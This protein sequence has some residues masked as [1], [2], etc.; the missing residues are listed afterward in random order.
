MLVPMDVLTQLKQ[1][2]IFQKVPEEQLQWLANKGE[3]ITYQPEEFAFQTGDPI[4]RLIIVFEGHAVFKLKQGNH[5]RVMGEM[6][7]GD[8]TG[9][10]P[11]SRADKA[12]GNA[13]VIEK[14]TIF[15]LK[16]EDFPEMK[17]TQDALTTSLVHLM[18]T[19]IREFTKNQQQDDKMMALGKL[20]AGLAHELNNPSAAIVRS[21]HSLESH[22]RILPEGFKR[23]LNIKVTDAQA[24]FVNRVLVEK[25]A[26]GVQTLTMMERSEKEDDLVDWLDDH[27]IDDADRLAENL[28][29]FGYGA[30][31]LEEMQ[32]QVPAES[33]ESVIFWIDQTLTTEKL[34]AEIA[35]ASGRINKLVSSIKSYTHMDQAPIKA[36]TD[37]TIGL[38]NTLTMLNHKINSNG[39]TVVKAYD[40]NLPHPNIL[41]SE[42][43]Q[44]WTNL[45]DNAI[46]AMEEAE[47]KT[48]TIKTY[49]E[50]EFVNVVITD[51]GSGIPEEIQSKIFDPFFTTKA[52]GKGTG[53]GMEVVHRIVKNQHNGA[54]TFTSKPGETAFKVCLPINAN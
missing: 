5:Y 2:E 23:L 8:I 35:E 32:V 44:V 17:A 4:N 52:V 37:I 33:L 15:V 43:N 30:D 27:D 20:S 13:Q 22:L 31:D 38:N 49:K 53:L 25:I 10:L 26:N 39:I 45:I 42:M 3:L 9:L 18:S 36:E 46:D 19:R 41:A 7:A 47:Q 24:D 29:E 6:K 16:K 34:L 14:L 1:I 28:V 11:Y 50:R 12:I 51:S 40:E 54:I 48:L 21:A